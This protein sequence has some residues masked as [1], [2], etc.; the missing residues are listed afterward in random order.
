MDKCLLF[1]V[2][3]FD[4]AVVADVFVFFEPGAGDDGH[5]VGDELF[6]DFAGANGAMVGDEVI[7]F[8]LFGKFSQSDRFVV[9]V[10]TWNLVRAEVIAKFL[11]SFIDAVIR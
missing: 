8:G 5:V 11:L 6:D 3:T 1:V 7:V 10:T 2:I 9:I 4:D